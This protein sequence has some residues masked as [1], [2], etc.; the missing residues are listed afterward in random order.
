MH[1][2]YFCTIRRA[3]EFDESLACGGKISRPVNQ[4]KLHRQRITPVRE[5]FEVRFNAIE[6]QR[7]HL[8]L[9]GRQ[10]R[11]IHDR[12]TGRVAIQKLDQRGI[13]KNDLDRIGVNYPVVLARKLA[14]KSIRT[15]LANRPNW[16]SLAAE[17]TPVRYCPAK[18]GGKLLRRNSLRRHRSPRHHHHR[19]AAQ[20]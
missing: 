15:F 17:K 3:D 7:D 16:R 8:C 2:Q 9:A 6:R 20:R 19:I 5:I 10:R 12:K 14:A 1:A 13:E 18:Y 4:A 11:T